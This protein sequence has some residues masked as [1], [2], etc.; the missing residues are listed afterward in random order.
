MRQGM[1]PLR[2]SPAP[3][4]LQDIVFV[5]VTH[6]PCEE[7]PG[8]H[9]E[10]QE[11]VKTCLTTMRQN[12]KRE[13]TFL[14]WDN[15]S[16]SDFR[17]WLQHIF[18][19]D[20]LIQSRNI[21]KNNARAAAV[22]MLPLGSIVCYSDDD[23]LYYDNWLQPQIDLL[24]NFPNVAAVTGYPVRTMFRWGC[25][26][27]VRWARENG[28]LEQG[29]F[30]PKEWEMDYADSIGRSHE[31]QVKA[32]LKDVDYRVTYDGM[33]A[34]TT[35]HHCQFIGYAVKLVQA[36]Q[37]DNGAMPDEKPTDIRLDQIGLRLATTERLCRHMGNVMDDKIRAELMEL[38]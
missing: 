11:I 27:T 29:R 19:P 6:V 7:Q 20:V 30:I 8:Y 4:A 18:E 2:L 31:D 15:D 34:Y 5:V 28:K 17:D 23:I 38:A 25:E 1:N 12:A 3:Y 37:M 24:S 32:T 22:N 36:L 10:R 13:H 35:A 9:K 21:G 16:R 14:V 33:Q 26:N